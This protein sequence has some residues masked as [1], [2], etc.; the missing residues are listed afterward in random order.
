MLDQLNA[1]SVSKRYAI[2]STLVCVVLVGAAFTGAGIR[3]ARSS[4]K[5]TWNASTSWSPTATIAWSYEP[6]PPIGP[7]YR[8]AFGYAGAIGPG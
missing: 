3:D 4:R 2:G 7:I 8:E 5:S 1:T 6:R